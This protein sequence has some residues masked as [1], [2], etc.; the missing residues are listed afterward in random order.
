MS[1]EIKTQAA[2]HLNIK[3]DAIRDIRLSADDVYLLVDRGSKGLRNEKLSLKGLKSLKQ[4][5]R[6]P[7]TPKQSESATAE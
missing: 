4:K 7:R 5:K 3:P 1:E 2:D 6:K